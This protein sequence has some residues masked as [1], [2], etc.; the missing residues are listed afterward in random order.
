M[1]Q[2]VSQQLHMKVTTRKMSS[3][4]VLCC[5]ASLYLFFLF[6]HVYLG[7]YIYMYGTN[8]LN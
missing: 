3:S 8:W 1:L 5:T 2:N 4:K 7:T 6:L